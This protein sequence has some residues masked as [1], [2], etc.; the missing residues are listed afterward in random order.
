MTDREISYIECILRYC[1]I[2][3][4]IQV[5][6]NKDYKEFLKNPEYQMSLCFALEQIG[7]Q[8]KKLRDL[9]YHIKYPELQLNQIAG[10]RNKIVHG[11]DSIDLNMVFDITIYDIPDLESK[12]KSIYLNNSFESANDIAAHAKEIK[13]RDS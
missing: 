13:G 3:E 11:Y 10:L 6:N 12:L 5:K 1:K 4:N 8:A 9:G 2:I 7:E